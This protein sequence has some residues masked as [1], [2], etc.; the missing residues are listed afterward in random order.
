M[1]KS[2]SAPCLHTLNT[3]IS[4]VGTSRAIKKTTSTNALSGL[5]GTDVSPLLNTI[6]NEIQLESILHI[7]SSQLGTCFIINKSLPSDILENPVYHSIDKN[8]AECILE[9]DPPEQETRH[10]DINSGLIRNQSYLDLCEMCDKTAER[11]ALY[12]RKIRQ[13]R[14]KNIQQ[15]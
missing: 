2:I 9:P 6:S 11:Y 1:K 15:L 13:S 14:K 7:P 8:M 3:N 5:L 4:I 12:L 10:T